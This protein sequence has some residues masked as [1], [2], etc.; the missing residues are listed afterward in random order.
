MDSI[1]WKI[2]DMIQ[3]GRITATHNRL[4]KKVCIVLSV[5]AKACLASLALGPATF[6]LVT[7]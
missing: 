2:S 1:N 3:I 7:E 5:Y 4:V 6:N